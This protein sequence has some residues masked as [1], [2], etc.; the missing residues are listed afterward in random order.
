M[1]ATAECAP[2][3]E[4]TGP[5]SREPAN[6][7]A[8]E[9]APAAVG[10]DGAASRHG[11]R[12]LLAVAV[13]GAGGML[14]RY[15]TARLGLWGA[16]VVPLT[17]ADLNL[18][19]ATPGQ[20]HALLEARLAPF[21]AGEYERVVVNAAG[22]IRQR[23]K[24]STLA[25]FLAVNALLPAALQR[26]AGPLRFRLV[27]ISTDCVFS[28]RHLPPGPPPPAQPPPPPA[29]A[30]AAG[31]AT[32]PALLRPPSP[33]PAPF[34]AA[35]P[36]APALLRPASRPAAGV[37]SGEAPNQRSLHGG[38]GPAEWLGY[39]EGDACDETEEA[40]AASKRAGERLLE[41]SDAC[42]LRTSIIGEEPEGGL[43]LL[44]WAI[45]QRGKTVSGFTT[46]QWNGVTCLQLADTLRELLHRGL[47][48]SGIRHVFSPAPVSKCQLLDMLSREYRLGLLVMPA[49]PLPAVDKR[50]ASSFTDLADP[51]TAALRAIPPLAAQI[52]ALRTFGLPPAPAPAAQ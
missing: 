49:A 43:S 5:G 21:P 39:L 51:A 25:D 41:G 23:A 26:A 34:L 17:R 1:A 7:A 50:L 20:I 32:P 28:G 13:L 19:E 38:S 42:V 6:S 14:G 46:H 27:H 2:T 36:V 31:A 3:G 16:R 22:L 45:G 35:P 18:G 15:L 10:T 8:G 9:A 30:S 44:A 52:R 40:Y 48:W 37:G 12:G 47:L 29:P 24:S 11:P 4:A 33:L